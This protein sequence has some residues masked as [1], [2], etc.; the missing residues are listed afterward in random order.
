MNW[1]S[2]ILR[3]CWRLHPCFSPRPRKTHF[4]LCSGNCGYKAIIQQTSK[5]MTFTA[6]LQTKGF[7]E[8]ALS[9]YYSSLGSLDLK[10]RWEGSTWVHLSLPSSNINQ[11][12][13][14]K[15]DKVLEES[16]AIFEDVNEE[17]IGLTHYYYRIGNRVQ[18]WEWILFTVLSS[19]LF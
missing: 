19:L 1:R 15:E 8:R 6:K 13:N 16:R 10:S 17:E 18:H 7:K 5:G 3:S 9:K 14:S 2:N 12:K 11:R 4:G